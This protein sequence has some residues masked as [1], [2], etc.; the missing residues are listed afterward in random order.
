RSFPE[1]PEAVVD[2]DVVISSTA[3][4]RTIITLDLL[5]EVM[6]Q[7]NVRSLLLIDIA[8]P[9]DIDPRVATLPGVH[10]YNLDDLQATVSEGIR[11]RMQEVVH[12]QSI[13]VGEV[14]V[15]GRWV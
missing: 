15:V 14:C 6:K 9:R 10:L 3:A 12:V 13:I 2:A 7:R 4:P 1:L 5:R 11:L 8:L